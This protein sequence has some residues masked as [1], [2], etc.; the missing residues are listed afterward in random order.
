MC[1]TFIKIC[2]HFGHA[3]IP[4]SSNR[5]AEAVGVT[6]SLHSEV[7]RNMPFILWKAV[8]SPVVLSAL[9]WCDRARLASEEGKPELAAACGRETT[10]IYFLLAVL[11]RVT[12]TESGQTKSPDSLLRRGD[13]VFVR[14]L[15]FPEGIV[16]HRPP[17]QSSWNWHLH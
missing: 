11:S 12:A 13:K 17:L 5:Y 6:L 15:I 8:G 14:L 4:S 16:G 7:D 3:S 1:T 2:F 10:A 9:H